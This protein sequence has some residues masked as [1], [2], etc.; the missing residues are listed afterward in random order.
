MEKKVISI[1]EMHIQQ[2]EDKIAP[3]AYVPPFFYEA[4]STPL[5]SMMIGRVETFL[6]PYMPSYDPWSYIFLY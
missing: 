5:T 1:D 3:W 2:L 6:S 4:Y